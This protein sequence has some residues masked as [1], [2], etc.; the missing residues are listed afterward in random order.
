MS[1]GSSLVPAL[2]TGFPPCSFDRDSR[3]ITTYEAIVSEGLC[4]ERLC[5]VIV[6]KPVTSDTEEP[7][8]LYVTF[9]SCFGIERK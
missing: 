5:I 2:G 1:V 8:G 7:S 9:F 6:G 3:I 4:I